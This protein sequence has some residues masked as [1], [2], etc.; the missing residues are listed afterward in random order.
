MSLFNTSSEPSKSKQTKNN[1]ALLSLGG[2]VGCGTLVIVLLGLFIGIGLDK[3]INPKVHVFTILFVLG[4]APLSLLFT[5]WL[6]MRALKRVNPQEP[7][8]KESKPVEEDEK[9]E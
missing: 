7:V 6:A 1:L 2:E 5:Y 4:S 3:L 9:R 8:V